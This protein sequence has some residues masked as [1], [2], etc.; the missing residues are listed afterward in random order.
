[1][2]RHTRDDPVTK[3]ARDDLFATSFYATVTDGEVDMESLR[4]LDNNQYPVELNIDRFHLRLATVA[5][6]LHDY[7]DHPELK[8]TG[9]TGALD[10]MRMV[11]LDHEYIGK[12]TNSLVDE[13]IEDAGEERKDEMPSIP[14][15]RK[16]FN[17]SALDGLNLKAL[18]DRIGVK[19]ETLRTRAIPAE[20][21]TK[22]LWRACNRPST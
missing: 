3:K 18:A 11:I 17:A 1:M 21:S 14:I 9:D 15:F 12:E 19:Q 2:K 10:R 20:G 22:T 16:G 6:C 13:E 8:S 4:R 7:F 5:D